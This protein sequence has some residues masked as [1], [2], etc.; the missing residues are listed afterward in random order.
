MVHTSRREQLLND[1]SCSPLKYFISGRGPANY[2]QAVN[3]KS[4]KGMSMLKSFGTAAAMF[5]ISHAAFAQ[6]GPG[7]VR[8]DLEP[9]PAFLA[10]LAPGAPA[11][12]AIVQRGN[13]T[14]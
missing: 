11:A 8:F 7:E 2:G 10:C 5:I 14:H 13:L 3:N 12:H 6:S 9:N 1:K 4:N